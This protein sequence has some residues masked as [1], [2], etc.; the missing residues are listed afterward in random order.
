MKRSYKTI[1]KIFF[2]LEVL[3]HVVMGGIYLVTGMIQR[4]NLKDLVITAAQYQ[5]FTGMQMVMIIYF[6]VQ[7]VIFII[8]Y[9]INKRAKVLDGPVIIAKPVEKIEE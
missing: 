6:V 8:F 3:V 4:F 7:I 2:G 1:L 9:I 5:S